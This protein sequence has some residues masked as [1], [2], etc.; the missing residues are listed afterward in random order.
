M[1]KT[2]FRGRFVSILI[3]LLFAFIIAVFIYNKNPLMAEAN[4]ITT[5][6]YKIRSSTS[7]EDEYSED[8][9]IIVLQE[10]YSQYSGISSDLLTKLENV[11]IAAV[12]ELT[13][14]PYEYITGNGLIDEN[15][16]PSLAQYYN[17]NP[18]H[19]ILKATLKES[20]KEK[21][22]NIISVIDNFPEVL[23]VGPDMIVSSDALSNDA[24][25]ALQWSVTGTNNID[26]INAWNLTTGNSDIRVGVTDSGIANHSD[27]NVN[28]V[29]GYDFYNNNSILVFTRQVETY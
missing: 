26:L 8:N 15:A 13:A 27:L 12:S 18:F 16:A 24:Y 2:A 1:N 14:L 20:G 5:D 9:V 21:V 6:N 28:V 3:I 29:E 23:H 17:E 4:V 10:T 7:I 22:L 19:Q 11:G 25:L